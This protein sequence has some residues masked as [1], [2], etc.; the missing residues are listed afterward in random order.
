M[1]SEIEA[2]VRDLAAMGFK[3]HDVYLAELIPVVELAWADGQIEPN[4]RALLESYCAALTDRLN[5]AAGA[6][7]FRLGHT[8]RVLDRLTQRR[9]SPAQR[10]VSVCA[11]KA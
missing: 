2:A 1:D 11:L 3:G 6:P 8:L 7:F 5:R 10:M 4:E 9:L